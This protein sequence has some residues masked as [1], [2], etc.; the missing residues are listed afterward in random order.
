VDL[1][2]DNLIDLPC[3]F[4]ITYD[5]MVTEQ[6]SN[7]GEAK[8]VTFSSFETD[9]PFCLDSFTQDTEDCDTLT[10]WPSLL[11]NGT[12]IEGEEEEEIIGEEIIVPPE[13][14]R[15][16][17]RFSGRWKLDGIT[18]NLL[19]YQ[20]TEFTDPGTYD[21][22]VTFTH[23][24]TGDKVYY[25]LTHEVGTFSNSEP[26]LNK[27]LEAQSVALGESIVYYLPSYSDDQTTDTHTVTLTL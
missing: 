24:I 25:K 6:F 20:V 10:S 11:P 19:N 8:T 14:S 16:L 23:D 1:N 27:E 26:F 21:I 3:E 4:K 17:S 12:Q 22:C 9:L 5:E 13:P 7:T 2:T 15:R 18:E